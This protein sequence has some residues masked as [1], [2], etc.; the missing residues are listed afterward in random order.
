MIHCKIYGNIMLYGKQ[1]LI[2]L[3]CPVFMWITF[4]SDD[5]HDC[6][7]YKV[8]H[9]LH[10]HCQSVLWIR[11]RAREDLSRGKPTIQLRPNEVRYWFGGWIARQ[12]N[13]HQARD[14]LSRFSKPALP[15]SENRATCFDDSERYAHSIFTTDY[16]SIEWMIWHYSWCWILH[17]CIGNKSRS[18][19]IKHFAFSFWM[20]IV[21]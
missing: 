9:D 6:F 10:C 17:T 7:L 3:T 18:L 1:N 8:L 4:K 14:W 19:T 16:I 2:I 12:R 15:W 13:L 21:Q 5:F 20:M 11:C